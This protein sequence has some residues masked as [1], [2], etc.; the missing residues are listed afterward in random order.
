MYLLL[1]ALES[2]V[3]AANTKNNRSRLAPTHCR[4]PSITATHHI[5]HTAHS[6]P[7]ATQTQY[8]RGRRI[9]RTLLTLRQ[10]KAW[11]LAHRDPLGRGRVSGTKRL[12]GSGL[13]GRCYTECDSGEGAGQGA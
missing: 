12:A 8:P 13:R 9:N 10:Y 11:L 5:V 2:E 6:C 1:L 4:R 3:E 7:A